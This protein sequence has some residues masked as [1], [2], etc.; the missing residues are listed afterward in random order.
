MY[1]LKAKILNTSVFYFPVGERCTI[2]QLKTFVVMLVLILC[3]SSVL[4]LADSTITVETI[5]NQ[6]KPGENAQYKLTIT[7]N[8]YENQRYS[9]YSFVQ[10]W[11]VDPSPLKDR[12]IEI[13][14]KGSYTT[15]IQ[16]RA[17]EDFPP[18]IYFVS[19]TIESD[20]GER[21]TEALKVY[22]SPESP[23][24]YLPSIQAT[25]DMDEKIIPQNPVPITLFLENKNPLDL[26]GLKIR[27][28]SDIPEFVKE[29][30][31]DLPPLGRKTVDFTIIP[32]Q[33]Q[34]P[35]K[36][37][38]FFVFERDGQTAKV[39]EQKIEVLT[40]IPPFDVSVEEDTIF[41]KTFR[42]ITVTN[43]GNV[44]NTQNVELPISFVGSLFTAG[45]TTGKNEQG[46]RVIIQEFSLR[47]N[48]TGSFQVITNYRWLL[49][50]ALIILATFIF[51][52]SVRSP[53]SLR[54]TAV[55]TK[56]DGEG[57]LS[58]IKVTIEVKN[59]SS[60]PLKDVTITDF[61]PPIA[62][63]KKSLELGTLQPKDIHHTKKHTAVVWSLA[64]L[65]VHEHRLITYKV[66]AKLNIL[67]SFRL[68]RATLEYKKGRKKRKAYSNVF[69]LG[70]K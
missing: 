24:D 6:I 65:D 38:L 14:A 41:L 58:E 31:V 55:T 57:I 28:Q 4:T 47:P 53:V 60:K 32:N 22:L 8:E 17:N 66:K 26:R 21:Y 43:P 35:K 19:V 34:Q 48:E 54:K 25:V 67:G 18:G 64:E 39:V 49:Y 30:F 62:N 13:G 7:N 56:K 40:V 11:G 61:V 10:G 51:Y 37:T 15:I 36:Y 23:T 69:S 3:F 42:F 16:A 52:M 12:I 50:L 70:N 33:F 45:V 5:K 59:T 29:V 2:V 20:L 68:P 46:D 1:V 9:I 27:I 44:L 63:V